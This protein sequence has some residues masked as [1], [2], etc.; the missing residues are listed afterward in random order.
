MPSSRTTRSSA[1][2]PKDR[3]ARGGTR[4][5]SSPRA[6]ATDRAGRAGRIGGGRSPLNPGFPKWAVISAVLVLLVAVGAWAVLSST[7]FGVRQIDVSGTR[8]VTAQQVKDAVALGPD[9]SLVTVDADAVEDRVEKLAPVADA[10][11]SRSWPGTLVVDVTER[12]PVA[13]VQVAGQPQVIDADGVPYAP[14]SALGTAAE[15]LLP[16]E[17]KNPSPDDHATREAVAV[18]GGLDEPTRQLVAK[19]TAESAAQVTLVLHDG[20]QVIWGDASKMNDK[21]TMLPVVLK[22]AGSV[23]DISSPTA[24]VIK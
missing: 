15:G 23:Y 13:I 10:R 22:K 12:S 9:D 24:I 21:L 1:V 2:R 18:I 16:L 19:V 8:L 20:R 5:A 14:A 3:P 11:V 4:T 17:L 6:T 7:F